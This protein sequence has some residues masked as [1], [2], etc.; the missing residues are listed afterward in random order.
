ME[1]ALIGVEESCMTAISG[2]TFVREPSKLCSSIT[3]EDEEIA[4]IYDG[5]TITITNFKGDAVLA[6]DALS[7]CVPAITGDDA[8][9]YVSVYGEYDIEAPETTTEEDTTTT[10]EDT[11]TTEETTTDVAVETSKPTT[12]TTSSTVSTS[13]STSSTTSST[14]SSSTTSATSPE[15]TSSTT[16]SASSAPQTF[17]VGAVAILMATFL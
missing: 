9:S 13:S 6:I 8:N 17:A 1:L 16:T 4:A 2:H 12:P 3:E 14:T 15:T 10:E 11:T 5:E 7:D